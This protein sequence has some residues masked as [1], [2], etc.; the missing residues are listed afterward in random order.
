MGE[1]LDDI[2]AGRGTDQ[3]TELLERL[4]VTLSDG[5]LCALGTTAANPVM[6]ALRYFRQE[7]DA[8]IKDKR[9]PAHVCKGLISYEIDRKK[10]TGCALCVKACQSKA[11]TLIAKKQPVVLDRAMCIKCGA[12]FDACRTDAIIVE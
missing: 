5:A 6:S 10:C 1:I 2:V 11:I 12:C 3:D 4:A 7:F 9:C 8:H